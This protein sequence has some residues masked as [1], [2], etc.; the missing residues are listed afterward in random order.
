MFIILH[1]YPNVT[2]FG[3]CNI[4]NTVIF[5][6]DVLGFRVVCFVICDTTSIRDAQVMYIS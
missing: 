3:Y 1:D 2:N 4:I 6:F 5:V